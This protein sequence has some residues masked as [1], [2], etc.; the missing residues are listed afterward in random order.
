MGITFSKSTNTDITEKVIRNF[1]KKVGTFSIEPFANSSTL[2]EINNI[3]KKYGS[4]IYN[5]LD[6]NLKICFLI[7]ICDLETTWVM[8][9]SAQL[10]GKLQFTH[11]RDP[12]VAFN[13]HWKKEIEKLTE[14][15]L[16]DLES[17]AAYKPLLTDLLPKDKPS[18][19]SK[20]EPTETVQAVFREAESTVDVLEFSTVTDTDTD[21]D[22]G[23][24]AGCGD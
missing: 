16:T 18:V 8:S 21:T 19:E 4:K 20:S 5:H 1:I 9:L 2:Q 14:T 22:T 6:R 15:I 12:E 7:R 13:A 17:L 24:G 10:C 11:A 3:A 23:A